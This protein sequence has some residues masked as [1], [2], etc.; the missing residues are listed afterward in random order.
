MGFIC[1]GAS[2]VPKNKVIHKVLVIGSGPIIIGQ[3]AEFDYAGTQACRALKEENIQV[4]LVNS[5]PATIM[6]DP[7]MAD[8]VYIEPLT[9][10]ILRNIIIK[11]SP[12]SLLPSLGGQTGLNLAME[13]AES[14][15][16]A[17]QGVTLLGTTVD[18]IRK[19][20]DRELFKETMTT[21]GEPTVESIIAHDIESALKFAEKIGYPVIVR[22]AYTLGGTGGGIATNAQELRAITSDGLRLS[23]VHQVLIE[24][25]LAGWKEIEYEVIRDVEGNCITVCNME[26]ID[27]V[28][29]H[30]GD[31]IVVAPAQTLN[32]QEHQMLKQAAMNII[33]ALKIEG[34][35][36]VQF[37]LDPKSMQY[38]VIEVNP[39]VSRSSALASK[40]TGYP[41]ARV[42]TKIAIGYKLNEIGHN[43]AGNSFANSEP[44]M[45]YIV[46]KIP[47]WPFDKFVKADKA[48]G[49]K[50]KATGEVM[51]IGSNL[52]E[53]LLKA[54]RSLEL[55]LDSLCMEHLF[56]MDTHE[57]IKHLYE[58]TDERLFVIAEALRRGL[59]V[60]EI[61]DRTS[62]EPF[63]LTKLQNIVKLEE[64]LKQ[65][66]FKQLEP[67]LLI[68]AK[69]MGFADEAIGRFVG[70][71]AREVRRKRQ[72]WGIHP[73]YKV[74]D[75]YAGQS[76]MANSYYYSTYGYH[77]NQMD[78]HDNKKILVIGSGPIRIGQG[79][80]FDYCSVHCVWALKKLGYDAVIINNNPETV[81]TDFDTSDRLYFEPL[82]AEDVLNVLEIE[83]PEGV[84]VQFGGQ[85]AIKL[86][87]AIDNAGYRILG[88]QPEDINKAEDRKEFDEMLEDLGILRPSGATVFTANEAV[89]A[90]EKLGY[91]VLVRPS[92]VL[93]GQGMEIAYSANNIVE[94]MEIIHRVKQE[95]P[96]LID[97][98][99]IGKE[100]EVDAVC[101]GEDI[102]IPG[103]MEHI[104][105]A[106][107]HSGDSI[108]VYPAHALSKTTIQ[109]IMDYTRKIA[110]ALQVKGLINIQYIEHNGDLYII[111]V[112]PRSSRT[113]P[114]LSKVTGVPMVHLATQVVMGQKLKDLGYGIGLYPPRNV[115]AVKVPVF[116]FEKLP[117]VEVSLGPEMKSTGE[118]LGIGRTLSEALYKGLLAAGYELKGHGNV[119][120]T[121]ANPD[122]QEAI[123]IASEFERLG[124]DIFAT[125]GTAHVL[126]FNYV[127]ASVVR[128]VSQKHPNISDY[129][130]EGQISIIVNTPT[131]GRLPQRDGFKI[132]RMAVEHSIP[133]MTSLDT[134]QAYVE[135]LKLGLDE[136]TLEPIALEDIT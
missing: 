63:F 92:Y 27:P 103:I 78:L 30:T 113:V 68:G 120:M 121:V 96:I 33:H 127:G 72:E 101:D 70:A 126:N 14:G 41:I 75:T 17:E 100:I 44:V 59:S 107:I 31:S 102:L 56:S 5:N 9:P 123:P 21:I 109:R 43:I 39:R 15:F 34:G 105:R 87:Q 80:E 136:E 13:L 115:V 108:A 82:T 64:Q 91:P 28:G 18:S 125:S 89:Q 110:L 67:A 61:H 24:K 119:L 106:G 55:G 37:A 93:G 4:V 133:C 26:N 23:R 79:I 51:A 32:T 86:A 99:L 128:K 97:K 22:P 48:L 129:I 66:Q 3:A 45:D 76:G 132:R 131:K 6:T 35:C 90:A 29:I 98:Y 62:I 1:K 58:K 7:N 84:M 124:F 54:V 77:G 83:K 71:P 104:E 73:A 134:A 50:M 20:E 122:K 16:L 46:V 130:Q 65:I 53:A 8:R 118:V 112:N 12:D 57:I 111:E 69:S 25:S 88:T 11:E 10:Q 81:S 114:Y 19:A 74:V 2:S 116:S 40:A 95:H 49:T 85:T 36:N 117:L 60:E 52:E 38:Y 47:R 94:Y 135:S 42:A